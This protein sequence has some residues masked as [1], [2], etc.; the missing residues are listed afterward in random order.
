MA[1]QK[2]TH[3][4]A[5]IGLSGGL[6]LA[7]PLAAYAATLPFDG[8]HYVVRTA[9]LPFALGAFAGIGFYAM[10]SAFYE[11]R[12]E[13]EEAEQ[14][15][16]DESLF[17]TGILDGGTGMF[18]RRGA[19]DSVPVIARAVDAMSEAEA[20]AEIDQLLSEDSPVSCDAST[21]KDIYQL[22]LEELARAASS[23]PDSTRATAAAGGATASGQA[24]AAGPASVS[25]NARD[26]SAAAGYTAGMP[27]LAAGSNGDAMQATSADLDLDEPSGVFA[28]T[29]DV[30]AAVVAADAA[31][32]KAAAEA[33]A[34]ADAAEAAAAVDVAEAAAPAPAGAPVAAAVA[35]GVPVG[36][37]ASAAFGDDAPVQEVVMVDYTGHEEMWARA[38]AVLEEDAAPVAAVGSYR[39]KHALRT[40]FIDDP[41]RARAVAEGARSTRMHSHVNEILSEELDRVESQGVRRTSHEYLRVI[42]GGTASMP[43]L[44]VEA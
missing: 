21:S 16:S 33:A 44:K 38:I 14:V 40:D 6:A 1:S 3:R 25:A 20:W 18:R 34:A 39:P 24:S 26:A 43:A 12:E 30:V 15:G 10:S 31:A 19:D 7:V 35:Q 36:D 23:S 13:A 32:A 11:S 2:H 37:E 17:A 9:G 27:V 22:A 4:S 8:V 41:A 29:D 42:Q 28:V 5:A